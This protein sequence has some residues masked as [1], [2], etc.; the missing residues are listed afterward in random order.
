MEPLDKRSLHKKV[1]EEIDC[2]AETD[3]LSE[4]GRIHHEPDNQEAALKWLAL[5]ILHGLN[6]NAER[7]G[8]K[9]DKDGK[10]DIEATYR[11]AELPHPD[12][13]VVNEI[14][15]II[16]EITHIEEDRGKIPLAVGVRDSSIDLM[17]KVEKKEGTESI[18]LRF[19]ETR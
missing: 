18:S 10:V 1:Q 9:R 8:L 15:N 14:F 4:L 6:T 3:Y 11:K 17:I 13:P 19:P 5:I 7:I 2:F 12:G 16:R